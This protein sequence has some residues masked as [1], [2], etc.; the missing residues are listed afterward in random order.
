MTTKFEDRY[1][2]HFLDALDL[3]EGKLVPVTIEHVAEPFSEKDTAGKPIKS[4]IIAFKG[5]HKRLVLN[6]TNFK[7]LKAMFSRDPKDWIGKTVNIQRRYLDAAHGFG[8][9]NTLAIR[10]VPP[11]GTPIL[12]SAANFMGS[13]TPYGTVPTKPKAAPRSEPAPEPSA[14]LSA[15]VEEWRTGIAAL[16]SMESCAEFRRDI[17]PGCPADIAEE[18]AKIISQRETELRPPTV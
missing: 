13:P 12:K 5:K 7:N 2:G 10:I 8:Q 4:A 16:T 11:V 1:E 3:P 9:N 14:Q 17:L 15:K 6:T 18:V